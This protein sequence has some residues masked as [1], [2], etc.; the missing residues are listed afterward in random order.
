LSS[1]KADATETCGGRTLDSHPA[2]KAAKNFEQ[3]AKKSHQLKLTSIVRRV[4]RM[5]IQGK[6][7]GRKLR[8][9]EIPRLSGGTHMGINRRTVG[10]FGSAVVA[11]HLHN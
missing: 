2:S 3:L 5:R 11:N 8:I 1:Q 9:A 6:L 4:T 7:S 10:P